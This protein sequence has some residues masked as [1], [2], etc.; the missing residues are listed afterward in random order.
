M[1]HHHMQNILQQRE[2][3]LFSMKKNVPFMNFDGL[4][5]F[6]SRHLS[7]LFFWYFFSQT[8][9]DIIL[10]HL[11]IKASNFFICVLSV[12]HVSEPHNKVVLTFDLIF[13]LFCVSCDVSEDQILFSI[14]KALV[15]SPILRFISC[16][17]PPSQLTMFSRYQNSSTSSTIFF[18]LHLSRSLLVVWAFCVDTQHHLF[19]CSHQSLGLYLH[20]LF[21]ESDEASSL[22]KS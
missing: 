20:M 10:K 3:F 4:Y 8:I 6:F 15:A 1:H 5:L 18:C 22:Q 11:F 7:R 2:T 12:F 13:V 16:S 9:L 21:I 14:L 19:C 17:V